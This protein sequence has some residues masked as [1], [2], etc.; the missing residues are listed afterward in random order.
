MSFV[1][2]G[3]EELGR[4]KW[5]NGPQARG[6]VAALR[7]AFDVELADLKFAVK[8]R[9]VTTCE[10][11]ALDDVGG[12]YVIERFPGE[13]F[14][15]YRARVRAAWATW[16]K[17]GTSAAIIDSL[18]AYGLPDVQIYASKEHTT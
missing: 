2:A 12:G 17:A 13:G 18:H 15:T 6:F 8:Q 4:V 1:D 3:L 9:F 7:A 10:D 14:V 16:R 5:L 11:E